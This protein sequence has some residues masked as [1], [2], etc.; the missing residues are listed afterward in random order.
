[1][2][3]RLSELWLA[4]QGFL[5]V[6]LVDGRRWPFTVEAVNGPYAH[7]YWVNRFIDWSRELPSSK[8]SKL[9]KAEIVSNLFPD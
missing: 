6:L 9:L 4:V 2:K 3:S 8:G 5:E 7:D 1:M